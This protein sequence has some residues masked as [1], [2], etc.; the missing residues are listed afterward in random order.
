MEKSIKLT[1]D[2]AKKLVGQNAALDVI[3]KANFT[4]KEL[5]LKPQDLFKTFADI[6]TF[7]G[8][9]AEQ[10]AERTKYDTVDERGYKKCKMIVYAMNG[11]KHVT[12][13]YYPWFNSTGSGSGFSFF[14]CIYVNAFSTVGSRLLFEDSSHATYAGKTFLAEYSEHIN[15]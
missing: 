7:H 1:V 8:E 12:E 2:Q 11:G 6:L 10:F 13:G 9:T 15:G 5:G 4:C 3:L 14:G